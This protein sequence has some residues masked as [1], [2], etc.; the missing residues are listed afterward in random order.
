MRPRLANFFAILLGGFFSFCVSQAHATDEA[1]EAIS[2]VVRLAP[3]IALV[4]R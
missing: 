4:V 3:D 2:A 1:R